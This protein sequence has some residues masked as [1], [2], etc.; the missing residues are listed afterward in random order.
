MKVDS[1]IIIMHVYYTLDGRFQPQHYAQYM[2]RQIHVHVSC[3]FIDT[4]TH[5][6]DTAVYDPIY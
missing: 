3:T 6:M 1:Y 2:F 5:I 4:P